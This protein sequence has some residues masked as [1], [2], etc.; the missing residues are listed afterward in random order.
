MADCGQILDSHQNTRH[1]KERADL[2]F[3]LSRTRPCCRQRQGKHERR[4]V[5]IHDVAAVSG[6]AV[7]I[8]SNWPSN[9]PR[10]VCRSC[11]RVKQSVYILLARQRVEPFTDRQIEL[12]STFADQAVIVD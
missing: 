3:D 1:A 4:L 10:L 7:D 5:H 11:A 8:L 6:Y 9:G 2:L 12:V